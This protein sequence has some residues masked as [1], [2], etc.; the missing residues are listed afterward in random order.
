[1]IVDLGPEGCIRHS[2]VN[3]FTRLP[4]VLLEF[5]VIVFWDHTIFLY[6]MLQQQAKDDKIRQQCPTSYVVGGFLASFLLL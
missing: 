2:T 6:G 5:V 3:L 4:D 1:M